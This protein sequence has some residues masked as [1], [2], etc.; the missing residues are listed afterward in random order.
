MKIGKKVTVTYQ[1]DSKGNKLEELRK[2]QR[3]AALR[4]QTQYCGNYIFE[5]GVLRRILVDGGF[6]YFSE[7]DTTYHYFLK[8]HLGSNRAVVN[9]KTGQV[10]EQYDYY[11]FGKQHGD[12][13]TGY[14]HPYRYNGKELDGIAGVDWL[15]YGARMME[16]EWGRFTTPDPMAEKYYDV[17]PYAYC[18]DNPMK[19]LDFDGQ[20]PTEQEAARIAAHVYG[21]QKDDI[22]IG[23]WQVSSTDFG[24]KNKVGLK[25]QVYE[26]LDDDGNVVEYVYATAG[27]EIK[28]DKDW[29][30]DVTQVM[31]L[32]EQ[33]HLS[34][35]NARNISKKL[36]KGVELNFVGHS[37]GG[38]EAALNS[39][40]TSGDGIGRKAFT[41][42]AAGLSLA[43]KIKEGGYTMPFKSENCI[44]AYITITDPLNLVQNGNNLLPSVNGNRHYRLPNRINGHSIDNFIRRK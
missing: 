41:F 38:G 9:A 39:L 7:N 23:N 22:L 2:V 13:H 3:A 37:L 11:P 8:D 25:S 43:T 35:E 18:L 26:R 12:Y 44:N 14:I 5:N 21:D 28:D 36:G 42:N 4:H 19:F 1:Y 31:G 16:P 10:A 34:A 27:T 40:L 29:V 33:Y 24:I 20:E 30:A 15:Y 6:I 32:S 17:S